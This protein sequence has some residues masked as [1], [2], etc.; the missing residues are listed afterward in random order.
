MRLHNTLFLTLGQNRLFWR[1]RVAFARVGFFGHREFFGLR[2][3]IQEHGI[4]TRAF[5]SLVRLTWGDLLLAP[6]FAVALQ[7]SDPYLTNIYATYGVEI[8]DDSEYGTL[9]ATVTGIGSIFIGLYYA[10]I[11]TIGGVIYSRVPNNIRDLLAQERV[12]N[13]YMRFLA[14]VTFS[15]VTLLAFQTAGF[16]P[17]VLAVPFFILASGISI[18]AFVRLGARVFDLFDPT[19]LSYHLFHQLRRNYGQI[20]AGEYRWSDPSFQSYANRSARSALD[21]LSTLADLT[22]RE[23]HLNGQPL[24]TLCKHLLSF[25]IAYEP[26]KKKIPTESHWYAK[27]YVHPD[28]YRSSDSITSLAHQTA[29]SLTPKVVLL[30]ISGELFAHS[31][32]VIS[33][34]TGLW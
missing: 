19:T 1:L 32:P 4:R 11:S 9:L 20:M 16:P 17:V 28:W 34:W 21:T 12:G 5:G 15:G 14:F 8:T 2:H 30:R 10:A 33:N 7:V 23:P 13:V 3:R 29:T 6:L 27:R 31:R 18:I 25:L 26:A 22:A 24:A